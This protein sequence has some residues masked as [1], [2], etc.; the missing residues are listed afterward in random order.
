M[1]CQEA[2]VSVHVKTAGYS[3][4][5]LCTWEFLVNTR[6]R[7]QNIT[8]KPEASRV[9]WLV[10]RSERRPRR[11]TTSREDIHEDSRQGEKANTRIHDEERRPPRGFTTRTRRE[12]QHED[13]RRAR[14]DTATSSKKYQE[15]ARKRIRE[16]DRHGLGHRRY[17]EGDCHQLERAAR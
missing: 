13:S 16:G 14:G 6:K 2:L 4:W 5:Q 17:H 11:I 8:M 9:S 3:P 7:T 10:T 1:Q 15:H 12:D